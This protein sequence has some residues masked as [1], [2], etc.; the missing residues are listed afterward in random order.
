MQFLCT[1]PPPLRVPLTYNFMQLYVISAAKVLS[2]E[3][4]TYIGSEQRGV[5]G[6]MPLMAGLT[7]VIFTVV[8]MMV[9]SYLL[10]T[11]L[12]YIIIHEENLKRRWSE[13]VMKK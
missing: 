2:H 13:S 11:S 12:K 4:L 1:K 5:S 7:K 10:F 3:L 6:S 8:F 9:S